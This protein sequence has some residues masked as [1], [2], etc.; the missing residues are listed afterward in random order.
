MTVPSGRH[1][2]NN[3]GARL[4]EKGSAKFEARNPHRMGCAKK[5]LRKTKNLSL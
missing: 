1:S 2:Q 4:M 5:A 3:A